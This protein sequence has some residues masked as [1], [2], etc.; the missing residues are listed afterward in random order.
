[1]K[2]GILYIMAFWFCGCG[3]SQPSYT[4]PKG[5][6]LTRPVIYQMPDDLVEISGVALYQGNSD[7]IF[8]EQD[9]KGKLYWLRPADN[10]ANSITFGKDGDFEDLAITDHQVIMLRS[11]G[12][13]FSFPLRQNG[14]FD[15][16]ALKSQVKKWKDLILPGEYESLYA[17]VAGQKLYVLCKDCPV[18]RHQPRVSGYI[19]S[20]KQELADG[21]NG[22]LV[23]SDLQPI[24][25]FAI[26]TR[27]IEVKLAGSP[28]TPAKTKKVAG[29]R[30][31][32]SAL[33]WNGRTK[34]WFVLSSVNKMLVITDANWQVQEVHLLK[35]SL[36][37]Q[38]E[39]MTFDK[40]NNLYISNEGSPPKKGTI[41]KFAFHPPV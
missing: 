3:N 2:I 24:G 5:Y 33:S 12:V 22:G 18:D 8:A 29:L 17:D 9:E 15:D 10:K 25:D 23:L 37:G 1:M 28:K 36:F 32:P 39:G 14:E 35:P 20:M 38:P 26:D 31:K 34:Q 21:E 13:L 41:L 7:L 40:E 19:L 6:D 4:S 27:Q 11:D 30:F 16:A